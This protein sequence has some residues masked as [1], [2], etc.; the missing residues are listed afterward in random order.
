MEKPYLLHSS[1]HSGKTKLM[2]SSAFEYKWE[3]AD[4]LASPRTSDYMSK[5]N[6]KGD[7]QARH[8]EMAKTQRQR[9]R[10]YKNQHKFVRRTLITSPKQMLDEILRINECSEKDLNSGTYW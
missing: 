2:R 9:I 7:D 6:T 8:A 3:R 5:T 1:A 4:D 10:Q